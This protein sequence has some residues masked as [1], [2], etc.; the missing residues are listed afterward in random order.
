MESPAMSVEEVTAEKATAK[1]KARMCAAKKKDACRHSIFR[2]EN[3]KRR[4]ML[5]CACG[6]RR[7]IKIASDGM[8]TVGR[9]VN[10]RKKKEES[11]GT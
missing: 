3:E 7:S 1:T 2:Y 4:R 6:C 11:N 5:C 9:W 8:A 10:P